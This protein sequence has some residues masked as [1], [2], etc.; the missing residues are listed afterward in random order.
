MKEIPYQNSNKR[1]ARNTISLYIRTIIV[2]IVQLYTSRVV[3][4]VLGIPDFGLWNLVASVVVSLSFI[5]GPLTNSTQRFLNY[6]M[7]LGPQGK[8]A[9]VFSQS[10]ILYLILGGILIIILEIFGLWFIDNKLDVA[11]SQ[12]QVAN[13]VFQFSLVSFLMTLIRMPYNAAI[14]AYEKMDF[15]AYISIFEAVLKL[16]IVYLLLIIHTYSSLIVYA[17]LTMAV[18]LIITIIYI[19]YCKI[20]FKLLKFQL[21]FDKSI[22]KSL[23]SFSSWSLFGSFS[24]MTS[25]QGVAWLL[26]SFLGVSINATW[27]I[28]QQVTGAVTQFVSNFQTAFNPQIVK[29]Y[30]ANEETKFTNMLIICSRVSFYLMLIISVPIALNMESL[31]KLWL[32]QIPP[33]LTIFCKISLAYLLVDTLSSSLNIGIY[34]SGKI[35]RY[36]LFIS[37]IL[38]L[39]LPLSYVSLKIGYPPVSTLVIRF[40]ISIFSLLYRI[41]YIDKLII[42]DIRTNLYRLLPRFLFITFICLLFPVIISYYTI[43]NWIIIT[44]LSILWTGAIIILYGFNQYERKYIYK[45]I[46]KKI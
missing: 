10:I 22:I 9:A 8:V 24:V 32:E 19:I 31:L 36:Q 1:L 18:T 41:N 28:T 4:N 39:T 7:G 26:N 15:Y 6:E 13:V 33:Y 3:L 30:A 44:L 35:K 12:I 17:A 46:R 21:K 40:A 25:N 14:I 11:E 42:S 38:L 16:G 34:A 27:G 23:T 43:L 2:M 20:Q 45:Y 5:T 37:C 29:T